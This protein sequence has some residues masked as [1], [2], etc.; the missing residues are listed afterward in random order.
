M[1]VEDAATADYSD[2]DVVLF[3]AGGGTSRALA[4][5]VAADGAIV[6][7]NS[8]AW[9]MD[10]D[11][12]LVVPEVNEAALADIAK[13]RREHRM[14]LIGTIDADLGMQRVWNGAE[15]AIAA[16]ASGDPKRFFDHPQL[17][18]GKFFVAG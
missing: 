10:P 13:G 18:A 16:Q 5:K 15:L 17:N 7:D 2:L 14:M 11:V 8:S 3:S 4:E 9:R 1:T 6:V 12:P